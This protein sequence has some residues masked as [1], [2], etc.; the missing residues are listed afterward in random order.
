MKKEYIGIPTFYLKIDEVEWKRGYDDGYEDCLKHLSEKD[1]SAEKF[2]SYKS[3][4]FAGYAQAQLNR[5]YLQ[6]HCQQ[7]TSS[8]ENKSA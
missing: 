5:A 1:C 6:L 8:A 3:G 7:S 4:Y 2:K